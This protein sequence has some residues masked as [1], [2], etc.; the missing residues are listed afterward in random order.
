VDTVWIAEE[1][2]I[3]D[4]RLL[5]GVRG[6][7]RNAFTV[8]NGHHLGVTP[9]NVGGA[10]KPVPRTGV[11]HRRAARGASEARQLAWRGEAGQGPSISYLEGPFLILQLLTGDQL[12]SPAGDGTSVST[13]SLRL[14]QRRLGVTSGAA[15][16]A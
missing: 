5:R 12:M 6:G 13:F 15:G 4:F 7:S 8:G 14:R 11:W 10:G 9:G 3:I 2:E 16:A 1:P